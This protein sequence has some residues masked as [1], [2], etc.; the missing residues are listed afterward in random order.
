M[1]NY[2]CSPVVWAFE[3]QAEL[4]G[5]QIAIQ[6]G[7]MQVTY[8]ALNRKANGLAALLTGFGVQAET[9]VGI[10]VDPGPLTAL[11]ILG[12]LKSGGTY[13]PISSA[14]PQD[15]VAYVVRDTAATVLL[16]EER[17][18]P[19]IGELTPHVIAL[20][21][22]FDELGDFGA[23]IPS[24]H[25]TPGQSAYILYTSGSAGN[26]KGV[27]VSH[28]SLAYYVKWHC[29]HLR[30]ALGHL[31]LPLSSS[32]SF[33]AGVTQFYTPLVL[34]RTQ[35]VL[36]R[37][38]MRQPQR[39]FEWYREHP[40]FGLYCVPTLWN[41]L[42]KFAEGKRESG[43][44]VTGPRAVLLSGEAVPG[45]LVERSIALWPGQRLWNLYGPTEA[46]ANGSAGELFAGQPVTIGAPIAG[47]SLHLVDEAMREIPVGRTG[48]EGE[49]CISG[50]GVATGY[51]NLPEL[52]R[53]RFLL[54][55]FNRNHGKRLFKTGD[56]AKYNA[57]GELVFIG[58]RDFQVKIRGHRVECGE[59]EAALARHAAVRQT[60][61]VYREHSQGE[62]ALIAYVTF[63]FAR[64]ASVDELRSFLASLLPDYMLPA[65]FVMLDEFPKLANGKTD[66]KQ[67][68]APGCVR[69]EL[70]YAFVAPRTVR[71]RHLIRV[72]E[73]TLGLEGLGADDNFFDLGGDSLKV[74][75]ALARLGPT[76][77][78]TVSYREFFDHPTPARLAGFLGS[79]EV[80]E[81]ERI[82]ER[83][84][85]ARPPEPQEHRAVYPCA[86]NQ[87]SLWLLTQT[88]P[89]LTAYNMQFS[90]RLE[91]ELD[92]TALAA[93][94][95][96]IL[97]RH[98]VLRSVVQ[99]D[100]GRPTMSVLDAF[101]PEIAVA[102]FSGIQAEAQ[103]HEWQ[104]MAE[105]EANRPFALET[106]PLIRFT[107]CRFGASSNRLLVTAHHLVCDGQSI[108]IFCRD[109]VKHY[110]AFKSGREFAVPAGA[111]QYQD[112]VLWQTAGA[113]ANAQ[114]SAIEFWKQ[115]LDGA[116]Q[117]LK[118]PADYARPAVRRFKGAVNI[119]RTGAE[120]KNKLAVFNRQEGVTSFMTLLAV[121]NLLLYR[122][123]G[124][125][126]LLVGCPVA[127]RPASDVE[128]LIGFFANT[129]VVR[130][131]VAKDETVRQL[132]AKVRDSVLESFEHQSAP[133]DRLVEA[134]R[135]DRSL[136]V[137]PLF[138]VLFAFHKKLPA[139]RVDEGMSFTAYEDGNTASKYDLALDVQDLDDD[140]ELR[141]TYSTDLYA[142][143]TADRFLKGFVSLLSSAIGQPEKGVAEC[144]LID[145]SDVAKIEEWNATAT[146]N[147]RGRGLL[148]LFE[149]Q[150]SRTPDRVALVAGDERLSYRALDAQANQLAH[151][152]AECGVKAGGVVGA[153][154]ERSAA[155]IVGLLAIL[156]AGA[157][158]LP[159]DPYYPKERIDYII[160]DSRVSVI[161]TERMLAERLP[162][163]ITAISM[164]ADWP[165]ISERSPAKLEG[166]AVDPRALMYLMYTSGST[167]TPKGVMVHHEGATNYV[168]WMQRAFPLS[169]ESAILSKT[170]INFDISVWEIFLPLISGARLVVGR[171]DDLQAPE[172]LAHLIRKEGITD[173]QFVPSALRAFV[174]SGEFAGCQSLRR[175]FSGGEALSA[176][177]QREVFEIFSGELHNLYG[178]TEASIYVCHWACQ[179]E[180]RRRSV[181]IGRPMDNCRIHIL[182][183]R[184]QPVP[185]GMTGEVY[186]GGPCV[187]TGYFRKPELTAAAF[188]ADPFS[189]DPG[190]RLFKTG[191]LGRYWSDGAIEFLGRCDRQAKVRGYRIELDEIE[192]HL[193]GHPQVKHA[194]IIVRED[195]A[196]DVRLVAYLLYREKQIP[197]TAEL[198]EYLRRKLPDYMIP[199]TFVTLDSIPLLPNN[200][201][202]VSALPKPEYEK[203]VHT[204]L[205][206]HYNNDCER[207]LATIWEE[208]LTTGQFG[209]EDSFFDVGGHSLL[210][211]ELRRLIE[212]RMGRAVS[213]IELFQFPTI[214]SL[215]R[216]ITRNDRPV[217]GIVADMARRA[218]L[219]RTRSKGRT[220]AR[221]S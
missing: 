64:Y 75:S 157:A 65:V 107:R 182:D 131:R 90:L 6:F 100:G 8:A 67:L 154:M 188:V 196:D 180:D 45:Q 80:F 78:G 133:F 97:R 156:K 14:D 38:T 197:E 163:G 72:W 29:E 171:R 55:P 115:Q 54:N 144:G 32:M 118:F 10:C 92:E 53:E 161:V 69:P 91:G 48:E 58:R 108:S 183:A 17:L 211:A 110:R 40:D 129:I 114:A 194:I 166:R 212:T 113:D 155:M 169:A 127:N 86:P 121:F 88:F 128:E 33:A 9:P 175:I 152:L 189:A 37:D 82:P 201:A 210:M 167:G 43:E 89:D 19:T 142:P 74:A 132:V 124:Q 120:M 177:L 162:E 102:D 46:T 206:R 101:E 21:R 173:I 200:K 57:G 139:G 111:M 174:D 39:V 79:A 137:T 16:T 104:R 50:D 84:Q 119:L 190:A 47:T 1:Q 130:T 123:S 149:D 112:W 125:D 160:R 5:D 209:P 185:I 36:P 4:D 148:R 145:A 109:F 184:L 168:L 93:S 126:D 150:V 146:D 70:G 12:V 7:D 41:E 203:T 170:S 15:R 214:R 216:H 85:A 204:E 122:Y 147:L 213:N 205:D 153:H 68:P 151:E 117:V 207:T 24:G 134:M 94:L 116:P 176:T 60:A 31:D 143:E 18:L 181:P 59:I 208:V 83:K 136:S 61:V 62:K 95:A 13:V 159:L 76:P 11:A 192:H 30:P 81:E 99:V 187:A 179:R 56:L 138:Q 35:H 25:S 178:P 217:S 193:S 215:A 219:G 165:R 22:V 96:A 106:G 71:E 3:A 49:I 202:N 98:E 52:T 20:D 73:Q 186:I 51:L 77:R 103:E 135:P 87:R 140:L 2:V 105:D 191:D 44:P 220:A 23:R 63:H 141:L 27:M 198:R 221:M 195:K 66:R 199:S 28:E 34:G 26:P 158:Y 42:V 164:D 218:A 172:A